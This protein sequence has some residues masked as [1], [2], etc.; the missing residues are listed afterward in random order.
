MQ[1]VAQIVAFKYRFDGL[2]I[3]VFEAQAIIGVVLTQ[4]IRR[5]ASGDF[6]VIDNDDVISFRSLFHIM[7]GQENGHIGIALHLD[8][9]FPDFFSRLR[10]KPGRR[11]IK[12]ENFGSVNQSP[13]DVGAALLTARKL[14]VLTF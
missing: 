12:K 2:L 11:L 14:F 9:C 13:G 10:I 4:F 7:S 8:N 5:S 3:K 1:S 6:T